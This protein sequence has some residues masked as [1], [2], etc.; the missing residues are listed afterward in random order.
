V[1]ALGGVEMEVP[2]AMDYDDHAQNLHIHLKPGRQRLNGAQAVQFVRF[3]KD[4][5]GDLGRIERQKQFLKEVA[6]Q[7][8]GV[9]SLLRWNQIV[10]ALRQAVQTDLTDGELLSMG[11]H[12]RGL[13]ADEFQTIALPGRPDYA[14]GVSYFFPAVANVQPLL[15]GKQAEPAQL[16]P[17]NVSRRGWIALNGSGRNG[18]ARRAARQMHAAGMQVVQI[19]NM[20]GGGSYPT[21][22]L[23]VSPETETAPILSQLRQVLGVSCTVRADT[24]LP[25]GVFALVLG[26]DYQPSSGSPG[27]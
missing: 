5:R 18:Y 2:I 19:G 26:D 14:R 10:P 17:L 7:S 9:N 22:E 13:R 12:L 1:D 4:G 27:L 23:R 24:R 21:S 3:R 8:L 15:E 6:R 20:P 25:A 16:L 11:Y